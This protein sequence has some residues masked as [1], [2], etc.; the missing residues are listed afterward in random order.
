MMHVSE[1]EYSAMK[2]KPTGPAA[3]APYKRYRPCKV[4]ENQP[5]VVRTFRK[6][7]FMVQPLHEVGKGITD[8]AIG[9]AGLTV[10]VEIKNGLKTASAR[11]YTPDQKKW[12]FAWAPAV[13]RC[14][15]TCK[16]DCLRVAAS[17]NAL[18]ELLH[19]Y[20]I[21]LEVKGSPDHQYL[22]KLY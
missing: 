4:D 16:A 17:V 18:I 9:K 12:H 19:A 20:Q 5:D 1:R 15:V 7:G 22:P 10:W 3:R 6:L 21:R 14:V 2:G 8:I 13:M 11:E